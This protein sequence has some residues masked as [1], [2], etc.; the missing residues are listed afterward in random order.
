MLQI[1]LLGY[2]GVQLSQ[3][4]PYTSPDSFDVDNA[5][6]DLVTNGAANVSWAPV[7][8]VNPRLEVDL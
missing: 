7:D 5:A 2:C 1:L 3:A 8:T 6:A 4:V